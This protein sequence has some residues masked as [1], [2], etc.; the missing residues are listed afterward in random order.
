[1]GFVHIPKCAG[2]TVRWQ[3][4]DRDELEGKFFGSTRIDDLGK[5]NLNHL[6]MSWLKMYFPDAFQSLNSVRS[7]TL[8]RDPMDRF[9]SAVAQRIRSDLQQEP[10]EMTAAAILGETS[11]ILRYLES[12]QDF[13]DYDYVYFARQRDYVFDG[14]EQVVQEVWPVERLNSMLDILEQ[15]HGI[16]LKRDQKWNPTVTYHHPWMIKPLNRLKDAAKSLLP[17]G[18][19]AALRDAAIRTFTSSG[20]PVLEDTL[21]TSDAVKRFVAD[22]Y[23]EDARLHRTALVKHPS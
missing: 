18:P 20:S 1:M 12:L 9:V 19:Y 8:V 17:V 21:H 14:A 11:E 15:D 4:R 22:Y 7:Y 16:V 5:V 13:P 6:P 10:S 23:A 3:L 2:S